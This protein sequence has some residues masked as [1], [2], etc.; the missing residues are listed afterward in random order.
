MAE[1]IELYQSILLFGGTGDLAKRKLYTSLFNL[2]KK[3]YLVSHFAVV[4][5]ARE[6]L[7]DD[8]FQQLVIKSIEKLGTES[9]VRDFASHFYYKAHD[10]TNLADYKQLADM[11]NELDEKYDTHGNRIFY[12]SVAPRFFGVIGQAIKTEGLMSETGYNRLMV[13]KPFGVDLQSAEEL[14]SQL[15]SGFEDNQLFRIDHYLGKEMVQ[16]IPALRF[17]NPILE[18]AWSKDFIKNIQVTLSEELGVEERAGY[19]NTAGALLDMIQNH[20]LQIV[21]WLAMEKPESFSDSDVR[22]A[23]NSVFS[24]LRIY[25]K[26]GVIDNFVRGQYGRGEEV[27]QK[28]YT[29]EPDVPADSRNDTF[30]AGRLYFDTPRWEGVPFYVRSGKR[31]AKKQ[32]RVDIVFKNSDFNFGPA[33]GGR[34]QENVLSIIIDPMGSLEWSING[35]AVT[36]DFQTD[37][38]VLNW[39]MSAEDKALAPDP[40]ERMI[41][42]TMNGDGSNFADWTGVQTSWK[43]IDAINNV[44]D[45]DDEGVPLEIYPSGSMGPQ[46][47]DYLLA[48]TGDHWVFNPTT[49]AE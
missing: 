27:W 45:K 35:K 29:E 19:Y 48:Q 28:A 26:Q 37:V 47:S 41:H 23:K 34:L 24:K 12:M 30:V 7:T 21:A 9:Q 39:T 16:N 22:A 43:F 40:Y 5:T 25:D 13:E 6:K 20:T 32:T 2:Y 4:G 42:D 31:L 33:N 44:W 15:T 17:G 8:E 1:N 46:A 14:Q 49:E 3:G 36:T 38:D 11:L 10:V 18:S